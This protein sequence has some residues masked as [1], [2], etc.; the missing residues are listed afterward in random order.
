MRSH[1]QLH[2]QYFRRHCDPSQPGKIQGIRREIRCGSCVGDGSGQICV[3]HGQAFRD[4]RSRKMER[5]RGKCAVLRLLDRATKLASIDGKKEEH[6][7]DCLHPALLGSGNGRLRAGIFAGIARVTIALP[8][9][10]LFARGRTAERTIA[11]AERY[12]ADRRR[13]RAS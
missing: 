13:A 2:R 11:A 10:L 9:T 6:P 3:R 1:L 8:A 5:P 4:G 7:G 12:R